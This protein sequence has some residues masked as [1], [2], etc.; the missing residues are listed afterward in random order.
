MTYLTRLACLPLAGAIATF[1]SPALAHMDPAEHGSVLAGFSH[2]LFGLDHILAMIVVGLWAAQI[3]SRAIWSVP[4]GFVA[5]MLAG[6]LL[7]LAGVPLPAVEPMI[8]ASSVVLGLLVA[9]A[10]R[11]AAHWAILT[12]A[13]F[14]LFHGHAH[15]TELGAAEALPYGAGFLLATIVLHGFGTLIGALLQ[16]QDLPLR[17]L[18]GGTALAGLILAVG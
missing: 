4:L 17:I 6:F 1:A 14:A 5:A 12:V 2:P 10:L 11:P 15:G 13:G 18:G 9:L 8:L 16:R 3:G 7:S